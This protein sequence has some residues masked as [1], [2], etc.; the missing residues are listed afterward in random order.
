MVTSLS[1][2]IMSDSG[3]RLGIV[4]DSTISGLPADDKQLQSALIDRGLDVDPCIWTEEDDPTLFDVLVLRSCWSYHRKVD[5]FTSWLE[6]V[7][8][9]GIQLFNPPSVVRWNIHKSYLTELADSGVSVIPTAIARDTTSVTLDEI[10]TQ[11]DGDRFVVKPAIATSSDGLWQF[12]TPVTSAERD[13]FDNQLHHRDLLV[14]PFR[15]QINEG[16]WSFVFFA[17]TYSHAFKSIPAA[18][19]FRAHANYGATTAPVSPEADH[20]EQAH[21]ALQTAADLLDINIT[22]VLYARVD[23]IDREDQLELVELELVEPYLRLRSPAHV[24]TF[25]DA[26]CEAV[27]HERVATGCYL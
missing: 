24:S 7:S 18:T 10:I 4:T 3:P 15:Q 25:A 6:D 23:G 21:A 11:F 22:S 12:S 1:Y 9:R 5:Q 27:E 13:R 16:E 8:N 2:P 26:I 19:D 14:Q 17:G 20:I